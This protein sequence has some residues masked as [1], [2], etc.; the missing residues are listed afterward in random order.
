MNNNYIIV[1]DDGSCFGGWSRLG[2]MCM[3]EPKD[4]RLAYRMSQTVAERTLG[5]VEK[6]THQKCSIEK[7]AV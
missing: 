2:S 7:F 6:F 5:K 4:K 1:S 3:H